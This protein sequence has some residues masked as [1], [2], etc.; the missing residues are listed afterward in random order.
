MPVNE[1]IHKLVYKCWKLIHF[2]FTEHKV[3]PL[4]VL[5]C[6]TKSPK[7]KH[8]HFMVKLYFTKQYYTIW[9]D[10][11][12]DKIINNMMRYDAMRYDA[13]RCDTMQY[14]AIR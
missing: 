11:R 2:S 4:N 13:M 9:Y 3:M 6:M 14:N 5:F 7:S 12:Q 10:A 8:V 1:L